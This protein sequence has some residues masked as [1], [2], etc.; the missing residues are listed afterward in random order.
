[1]LSS[2]TPV[3]H[4]TCQ[5]NSESELPWCQKPLEARAHTV[6][7]AQKRKS[8]PNYLWREILIPSRKNML[9]LSI[10]YINFIHGDL[11]PVCGSNF[12]LHRMLSKIIGFF[13]VIEKVRIPIF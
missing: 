1:M 6:Y 7:K 8:L 5:L 3:I 10:F 11:F 9:Y 13:L 2:L 12:Y 4:L